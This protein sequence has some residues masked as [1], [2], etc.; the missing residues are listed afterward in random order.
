MT[1]SKLVFD[2]FSSEHYDDPRDTCRRM[3]DEAPCT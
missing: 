3:R 1:P 2:P